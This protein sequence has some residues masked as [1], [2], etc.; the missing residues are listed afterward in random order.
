MTK[1]EFQ[2]LQSHQ[3]ESGLG[4]MHYLKRES[5]PYSNYNYWNKKFSEETERNNNLPLAPI[6]FVDEPTVE[7]AVTVTPFAHQYDTSAAAPEGISVMLPNGVRVHF[8]PGMASA[9][10][11][12][13]TQNL[14]AHVLPE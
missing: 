12:L 13:L 14:I 6:T 7:R 1:E 4:L 8:S 3:K 5:I 2:Q 10:L 11:Q 9:A